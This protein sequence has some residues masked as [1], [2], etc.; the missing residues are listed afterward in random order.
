MLTFFST[1]LSYCILYANEKD[2]HDPHDISVYGDKGSLLGLRLFLP[3][4][5]LSFFETK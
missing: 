4:I 2:V 5:R 1:D 3:A